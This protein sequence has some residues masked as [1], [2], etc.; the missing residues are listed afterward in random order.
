V[1]PHVPLT[2]FL[3]IAMPTLKANHRI[4]AAARPIGGKRTRYRIEDVD[5]LWL[6][7]G[8]RSSRVWYVRYQPGG[9]MTRSFRYYK[10]GPLEQVSLAVATRRAKEIIGEVY[11]KQRDPQAERVARN[12]QGTTFGDLFEDWFA[13]HAEPMLARAET[14]RIIYRCHIEGGFSKR[15]IV[16]LRRIEIGRFRDKVAREASPLTSNSVV[17]LINRVLNWAV[18]EGIIEVNPAARLRKVGIKRPRERVLSEADMPKFWS[19]L[20]A[21]ET[22]TGEHM[23]RAEKGRM[24][25]PAT[26]SILRLLLLTGQRRSEVVEARKL[27][28][29]LD[30]SEPVWTIPGARTKNRLLHRLPLCPMAAAEFR[31]AIAASPEESP[32]VFPSPEDP[33]MRPIS[34]EAVTRAMARMVAEMKI[35]TVSPHDLRRTVGTEMAKLG[36]PVHVRS[37][38]LNHSPMSRGITDAVYNRYAYDKEKREALKAWEERLTRLL[39]HEPPQ[40]LNPAEAA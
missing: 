39:A 12:K 25:S 10:I 14:D 23:A 19:A 21:M 36:L 40:A 28:F 27:E 29:E 16:D 26:R 20:A 24:L 4:I 34:A 6:D 32:F 31:R 22:M 1:F 9:R 30:G 5:G 7:V 17:D 37:L 38:V 2:F 33:L 3:S 8:P 18:D 11:G 35:P 13:R 15:R